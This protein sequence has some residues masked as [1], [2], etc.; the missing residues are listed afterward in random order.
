MGGERSISLRIGASE[1]RSRDG[2]AR[3][4]VHD[5]LLQAGITVNH[6]CQVVRRLQAEHHVDIGQA[7]VNKDRKHGARI[8]TREASDRGRVRLAGR[9]RKT[10]LFESAAFISVSLFHGLRR[11]FRMVPLS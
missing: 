1:P 3:R 10:G 6:I 7:Q 4:A 9:R 8:T 2:R 5:D 11:C